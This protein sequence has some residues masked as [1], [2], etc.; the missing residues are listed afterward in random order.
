MYEQDTV[1]SFVRHF[2]PLASGAGPHIQIPAVT[3]THGC[4][5]STPNAAAVAAATAG[6]D[7]AV[8]IPKGSKFDIPA[9]SCTVAAGIPEKLTLFCDVT[10][11]DPGAVPFVHI[12]EAPVT[13]GI[14][15][16]TTAF[17]LN[18][19]FCTYTPS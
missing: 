9:L 5:V 12:H 1:P 6:F 10:T 3:G 13:T 14:A 18:S 8:H 4:G 7:I 2:K 11:S 16:I 17:F 19:G 15:I